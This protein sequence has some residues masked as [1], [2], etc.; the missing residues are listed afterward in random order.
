MPQITL[1]QENEIL[2][3]PKGENLYRVLA[4]HGF[5]DAPC[6]GV[7]CCGK[8]RV[9]I[10]GPSQ[11]TPQ[12]TEATFFTPAEQEAG[13]RLA[14][15][16]TVTEDI[17]VEL[18]ESQ[19]VA[20][21]ISS[22][23]CV[24]F[25]M[26]PEI[27]KRLDG[28]GNTVVWQGKEIIAME[29]GDHTKNC[30]GVAIDIG[31]TTIVASFLDFT[32]GKEM[33]SL[34]CLNSQKAFGQDVI[35][36]I[37]YAVNNGLGG[38]ILQKTILQD[39]R[40]LLEDFLTEHHLSPCD[41]VA[42]T[43]AANTTM[44]HLLAGQPVAS[45][46]NFPYLPAFQGPWQVNGIDWQLPVASYCQIYCLPAVAA[47][48]GGDITA[49][50]L[51]CGL[52]ETKENILF[53]D[54]GTNGEMVLAKEGQLCAC[55]CAA[56]PAL[57]GMNISCGVRAAQGA[58]ED[59]TILNG[60]VAYTT[61]GGGMPTGLCGSGLLS[62]VAE[63]RRTGILQKSGRLRE[64]AL[65]ETVDGK[66]R[67]VLDATYGISLTQQDIRHVQLAKGAILAGIYALL[68]AA[69]LTLDQVD[70]VLVAGQFGAHLKADSLTGAGFIPQEL[71]ERIAYVG[72]TAKSGAVMCLLGADQR[73]QAEDI[74]ANVNYIELS[75]LDGYNDLFVKCMEF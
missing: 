17:I 13:W 22:G 25:T 41:I 70:K 10:I 20:E 47:F 29:A 71:G 18:P 55:S 56:G 51:A 19:Q 52:Q 48:V 63:L 75:T 28:E 44:V 65:V 39:I 72:N 12:T 53:L 31:T 15:L 64:H 49:G 46:G 43:I 58:I 23:Y 5:M 21:I 3:C 42:I 8:C 11:T 69:E 26:Q 16:Y 62:A 14:C 74:V 36:R 1:C 60:E 2:T 50:I 32:S 7:G 35:S 33:T 40:L 27:Q 61:I 30:Y 4:A 6:G 66:R 45:L 34:S 37:H 59:V 73:R 67:F 54:I 24:P 57:E 38:V 9:R 68:A